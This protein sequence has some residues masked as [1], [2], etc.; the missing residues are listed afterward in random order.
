MIAA[1][2]VGGTF[3]VITLIGMQEARAVA[4]PSMQP[5]SWEP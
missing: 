2:L 3:M 5:P 4:G 1:L